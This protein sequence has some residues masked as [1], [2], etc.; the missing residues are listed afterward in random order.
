MSEGSSIRV[1]VLN[2]EF[3]PIGGGSA[4]QLYYTLKEFAHQ[5]SLHIDLITSSANRYKKEQFAENITI[6]YLD[7]RKAGDLHHQSVHDLLVYSHRAFW[8]ARRLIRQQ[9]FDFIHAYF[10]IPCGYVAMHLPLPYI[11][12]LQG[13]D[14][15][16]H[17]PRYRLLDIL[18]F[19]RQSR[20]VW[21]RSE[22][23]VANSQGLKEEALQTNP[24]QDFVIIYNGIDTNFFKP[25]DKI[26]HNTTYTLI[27]TGRLAPHK[28]FDHLIRA[29]Q[30][31]EGLKL[32]LV[33]S[34]HQRDYL[35]RLADDMGVVL[36][37]TGKIPHQEVKQHLQT[38]DLFVLPSL[39]EG[40]SNAALEAMAC[41]LPVILTDVG[42]SQ[43]LVNG[44][45]FVVEKASDEAL[46]QPLLK[47][48]QQPE[49]LEE[50]GLKSRQIAESMS[51]VKH[52]E[53]Y[54]NLYKKTV[55]IS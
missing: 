44:N 26:S 29:M 30:G 43:E 35:A 31:L 46:R 23:V 13:S 33:G 37:F 55:D 50:H 22:A 2:Y 27:S 21:R 45:G 28:G 52:A 41:G 39:N 36:E 6:H 8:Y 40:M 15:P 34:G 24:Q 9:K 19:K 47:Y 4:N 42:G 5:Q 49:L 18:F 7:I 54:M 11:V 51:W 38:A 16:F 10:G 48:L 1:L 25:S 17:T 12:S 32:K 20:R 3:P 53:N 14:V